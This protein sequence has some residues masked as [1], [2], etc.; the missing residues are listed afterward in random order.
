MMP[1][2]IVLALV[3][4]ALLFLLAGSSMRF[5]FGSEAASRR[6]REVTCRIAAHSSWAREMTFIALFW[7]IGGT[8][9]FAFGIALWINRGITWEVFRSVTSVQ[10]PICFGSFLMLWG[11]LLYRRWTRP[12]VI[13]WLA[14]S[15]DEALEEY[16]RLTYRFPVR[17]VCLL[18]GS[19]IDGKPPTGPFFG[20]KR[21]E[22][23]VDNLRIPE[24]AEQDWK[25][26]VRDLG[27][28]V[29]L[30][31]IR[32]PSMT[33]NVNEPVSFELEMVVA[34]GLARKTIVYCEDPGSDGRVRGIVNAGG[35]LVSNEDELYAA[36]G[37]RRTWRA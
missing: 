21:G 35:T 16:R 25:Q 26:N 33:S 1:L 34:E 29:L 4:G 9:L 20:A 7:V 36:M 15:G 8:L 10:A 22:M 23:T 3:F 30:I 28:V 32:L 24:E 14:E 12:A 18:R 2:V 13:L 6:A 5:V 37:Q 27:K 31:V 17:A 19:W 11:T